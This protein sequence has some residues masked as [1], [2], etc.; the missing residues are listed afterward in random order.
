MVTW[1]KT[2]LAVTCWTSCHV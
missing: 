1:I 2:E